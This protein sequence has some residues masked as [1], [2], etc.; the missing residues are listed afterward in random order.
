ML[1]SWALT[2][3]E[4]R[5]VWLDNKSF[6]VAIA[7]PNPCVAPE[8]RCFMPTFTGTPPSPHAGDINP[9]TKLI[10]PHHGVT[11][12]QRQS[13]R[14]MLIRD[15]MTFAA[16]AAALGLL[17]WQVREA[18][19]T[20]RLPAKGRSRASLNVSLEAAE[21]FKSKSLPGEAVWETVNRLIPSIH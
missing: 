8:K 2:L 12:E 11:E 3:V 20:V 21:F 9:A 16:I 1:F 13:A 7:C 10:R 14:L 6:F 19:S 5:F 15:G 17:E 4:I 18:L